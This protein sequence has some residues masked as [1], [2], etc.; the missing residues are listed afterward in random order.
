MYNAPPKLT[1]SLKL[2]A[3]HCKVD[4]M[5]QTAVELDRAKLARKAVAPPIM[6]QSRYSML[7]RCLDSM[8]CGM[9]EWNSGTVEKW[10]GGWG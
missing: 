2:A 5:Y 3:N 7:S 4:Y 9:V 8:E 1:I 10:N 6:L